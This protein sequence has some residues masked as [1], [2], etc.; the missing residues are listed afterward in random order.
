MK[1][2]PALFMNRMTETCKTELG[3][4]HVMDT[5]QVSVWFQDAAWKESPH[6]TALLAEWGSGSI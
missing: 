2:Y 6:R 1:L 3:Y 4:G 5:T